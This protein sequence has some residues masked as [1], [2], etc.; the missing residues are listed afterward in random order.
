MPGA[1]SARLEPALHRLRERVEAAEGADVDH[2]LTH[3]ALAVEAEEVDAVELA[4][5]RPWR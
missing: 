1:S 2:H 4:V 3:P 5:A